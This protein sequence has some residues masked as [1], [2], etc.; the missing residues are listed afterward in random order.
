MESTDHVD[1]NKKQASFT[2]NLHNAN[3][4]SNFI[5]YKPN[6]YDIYLFVRF[7]KK[8]R[9]S[10]ANTLAITKLQHPSQIQSIL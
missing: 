5:V 1:I 7:Y 4:K 3:H 10:F 8:L 2:R 6:I 9:K